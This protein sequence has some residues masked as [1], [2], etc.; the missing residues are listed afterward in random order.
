MNAPVRE[1]SVEV[2]GGR[3]WYCVR[4]DDGR[5]PLVVVHGGPGATHEYLEPLAALADERPV[6][7]YDQLGAGRS[8]V[9][10]D[11]GLWTTDRLVGELT[12]LIDSLPYP[13]VHL[14][15]QSWG[16]LVVGEYALRR[17]DRVAGAVF[18]DPILSVPRYTA[19]AAALR[20][21]LP[22]EVRD[23]L[24]EHEAAGTTDSEEYQAATMAFL[25]RH[26]CRL[27]PW[28]EPLQRSFAHLNMLIYEQ[29]WGP[30]EFT[31]TGTDKDYDVTDRLDRLAVPALFLCGRHDEARPED[32]E[33][34]RDLVRG[35][36]LVIFENSSH[37]PH[38][39][40]PALYLEVVRAFLAGAESA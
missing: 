21:A 15:G 7:F 29:M 33:Y 32:T 20:A 35:A 23:V 9:P 26:L 34:Y 22:P 4:G 3:V 28:P 8:D 19:G 36:D 6:V 17:P 1:G 38:L 31:A 11:P 24:D 30:N 14:L 40:E 12:T 39:E 13:K 16:A 25:N 37:M 18:A 2:T 10:D 5:V 27:D